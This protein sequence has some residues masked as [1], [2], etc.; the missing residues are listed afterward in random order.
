A[1]LVP[2]DGSELSKRALPYA[3]ALAC[4]QRRRLVL[5]RVLDDALRVLVPLDGS[6]LAEQAVTP[7]LAVVAPIVAEVVLL[8]VVPPPSSAVGPY[9]LED[10]PAEVAEAQRGLDCVAERLR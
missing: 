6:E 1:V 5:A 9:L 2:L 10:R 4:A 7:L 8:S 3:L